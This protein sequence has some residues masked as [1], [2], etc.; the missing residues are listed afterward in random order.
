M[1]EKPSVKLLKKHRKDCLA[2]QHVKEAFWDTAWAF[3]ERIVFKSSRCDNR[4]RSTMWHIMKC[5]NPDCPA[6]VA[7]TNDAICALV[8][9]ELRWNKRSKFLKRLQEV[10]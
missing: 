1:K 8:D 9:T 2:V 3:P 5:N 7:V 10:A 6:E 4:G